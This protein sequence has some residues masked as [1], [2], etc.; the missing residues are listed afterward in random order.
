MIPWPHQISLAEQGLS[1]LKKYGIVYLAME[2][3]TGKSLTAILMAET[4][5]AKRI[6]IITKKKAKQIIQR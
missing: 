4:S 5:L 2:E 1:I 6:L 3:R